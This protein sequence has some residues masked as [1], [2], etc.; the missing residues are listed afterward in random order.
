[1]S[2]FFS[3][4]GGFRAR[5]AKP[6]ALVLCVLLSL[7]L[8]PLGACAM[9]ALITKEGRLISDYRPVGNASDFWDFDD[10]YDYLGFVMS[11][12][13][14]YLNSD[15]YGIVAYHENDPS[16]NSRR[17]WH[18]RV[19]SLADFGYMYY[20]GPYFRYNDQT[21]IQ[22]RDTFDEALR[23]IM[24]GGDRPAIVLCHA[25]NATGPTL[26][27]HPFTFEYRGRNFSFMHNG[28]A[29]VARAYMIGRINDMNPGLNWF[30]A[31][32]SNYFGETD[33]QDWV[34]TE[35]LFHYIMSH[36]EAGG[37]ADPLPGIVNAL[38]GIA[39]Y[40]QDSRTGVYNFIMSD[41]IKLYA[42]RST[43]WTGNNSHYKLSY[44]IFEDAY[45]AVRTQAPAEGDIQL[46]PRELVVFSRNAKP[47]H[48]M[49][50]DPDLFVAGI[51]DPPP[52]TSR[53]RLE[54]KLKISLTPNPMRSPDGQIVLRI[55]APFD[56]NQVAGTL[57]LYNLKGQRVLRKE[58][59]MLS[60]MTLRQ[61][62][63]SEIPNGVYLCRIVAGSFTTGI[64][65]TIT[66]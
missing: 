38:R 56:G 25:R 7:N 6:V 51:S 37:F 15:G 14:P 36:I 45:Y 3:A 41:G 9:S 64:K 18:K 58:L 30:V 40:L 4:L 11:T 66:R 27:N 13:V 26:G 46:K 55:T 12:S 31:H 49:V 10:P 52:A 5:A 24:N 50:L 16:L 43:P 57:D 42:F 1:M 48:Y 63:I 44:R 60:G 35:V 47:D 53:H 34:D 62:D 2:L 65:I 61:L 23:T 22:S 32:P 20:T 33:P 19:Q 28:F 29:N 54:G 21:D 39:D 17:I 59:G 8:G